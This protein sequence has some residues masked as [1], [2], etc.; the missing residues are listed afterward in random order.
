MVGQRFRECPAE[1]VRPV[2][3][4][5]ELVPLLLTTRR[6]EESVGTQVQ[7][8]ATRATTTVPRT[9]TISSV[10]D[11]CFSGNEPAQKSEGRTRPENDQRWI[12]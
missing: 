1:T 11:A 10:R 12:D 2:I 6:L 3:A 7:I 5:L 9:R 4:P 8:A